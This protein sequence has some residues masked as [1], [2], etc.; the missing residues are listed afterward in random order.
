MGKGVAGQELQQPPLQLPLSQPP[1]GVEEF[2]LRTAHIGALEQLPGQ[3]AV[4]L[5]LPDQQGKH[6]LADQQVA[7]VPPQQLV[8]GLRLLEVPLRGAEEQLH[9]PEGGLGIDRQAP[10][11]AGQAGRAG[12]GPVCRDVWG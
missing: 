11:T 7:H 8:C 5:H 3:A 12:E 2:L 6:L 1:A 9:H 4:F 10:G